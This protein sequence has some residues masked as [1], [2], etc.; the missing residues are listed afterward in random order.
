MFASDTSS[1]PQRTRRLDTFPSAIA[2]TAA[3]HVQREGERPSPPFAAAV[4]LIPVAL[5]MRLALGHSCAPKSPFAWTH[6]IQ[7]AH[8]GAA[9]SSSQ[10]ALLDDPRTNE[11]RNELQFS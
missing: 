6:A 7:L 2:K 3:V 5:R 4:A 10:L 1:L 9:R 11:A 8:T